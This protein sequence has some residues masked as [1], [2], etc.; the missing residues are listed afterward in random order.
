MILPAD[1]TSP[2]AEAA[3]QRAVMARSAEDRLRMATSMWS[4]GKR[5]VESGLRAQGVAD[6]IE[7]K[8]R[9]FLRMYST[10]FESATL[11]RIASWLRTKSESTPVA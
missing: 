9:T 2:A 11:A 4:T 6:D 10:D 7:L 3:Y 8:V 5:L 1:D